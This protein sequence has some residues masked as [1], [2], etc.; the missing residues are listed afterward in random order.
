MPQPNVQ[1]LAQA[2]T[3]WKT[4]F[5]AVYFESNGGF[6]TVAL[7][8]ASIIGL[9]ASGDLTDSTMLAASAGWVLA[10]PLVLALPASLV[11]G[12]Y[13]SSAN[14]ENVESMAAVTVLAQE[15]EERDG[16]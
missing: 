5:C 8:L 9:A 16:A 14:F 4:R 11:A 3:A 1:T 7:I 6:V 15:F 12:P 2:R 10:M 13:P